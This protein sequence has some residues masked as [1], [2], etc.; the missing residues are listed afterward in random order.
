MIVPGTA[1]SLGR[2]GASR[3]PDDRDGDGRLVT[4]NEADRL[5]VVGAAEHALAIG[6]TN[7]AGLFAYLIRGRLWRYLTG[8]DEDKANAR[9]KAHLRGPEPPAVSAFPGGSPGQIPCSMPRPIGSDGRSQDA[10]IVR[11]VRAGMIREGI[12]RDPWPAFQARN[13]GWDRGRWDAAM[14]ELGLA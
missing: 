4:E 10:R 11:E 6:K 13:P 1:R 8:T 9:I 3:R 14:A 2:G 7:P 12:F 5:H